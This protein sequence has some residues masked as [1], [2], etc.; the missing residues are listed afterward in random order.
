MRSRPPSLEL[1]DASLRQLVPLHL[2]ERLAALLALDAARRGGAPP[3]SEPE[4]TSA[5]GSLARPRPS[6]EL[7]PYRHPWARKG[8]PRSA[9][10]R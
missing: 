9:W 3:P 1:R 4:P 2:Q 8:R 6:D 10:P 7:G 5:H